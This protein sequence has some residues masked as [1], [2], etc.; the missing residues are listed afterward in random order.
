[1]LD[2][3]LIREQPEFVR[4]RLASR[5]VGDE[6]AIDLL[7][8]LDDQ[9]RELL[10]KVEGLKAQRNRISKEIGSLMTHKKFDD[11]EAKK[12]EAKKTEVKGIGDKISD[13]DKKIAKAK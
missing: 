5:G 4:Q 10:T 13:L 6:V 2:L 3:K 9:R 11:A 8:K 1:M 12:V 7:L